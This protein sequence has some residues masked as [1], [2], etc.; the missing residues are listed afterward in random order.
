MNEDKNKKITCYS[1]G[2]QDMMNKTQQWRGTLFEPL[3][4]LLVK[5][6]ITPNILTFISLLSG[7]AF[8]FVFYTNKPTAFILLALHVLLDGLDGPLARYTGR[9]SNQGSFTDTTADQIV[10]TCSTIAFIHAGYISI[11][12]GGLYIF[13][14][15]M[16]VI[17]AMVRSTLAIPYSWLVRPRFIVYTWFIIE[18]YLLP[19]SINYV[20]WF[21]TFLLGIKMLTGFIKIRKKL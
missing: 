1:D 10:V 20:L 13:L 21:F 8:C 18:V 12:A 11:V 14:Y 15:T 3:L 19:G 6:K 9:A 7:I 16:V 4:Q 5:L 17:F 2:E